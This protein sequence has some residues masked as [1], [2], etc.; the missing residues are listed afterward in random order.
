MVS[1]LKGKSNVVHRA[2]RSKKRRTAEAA[3]VLRKHDGM[4][5]L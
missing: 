1:L 4:I 3:G 2:A 5:R